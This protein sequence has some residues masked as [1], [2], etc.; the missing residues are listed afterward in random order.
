MKGDAAQPGCRGCELAIRRHT[1]AT[2]E[3]A[4][5]VVSAAREQQFG[6]LLRLVPLRRES[7]SSFV[8]AVCRSSQASGTNSIAGGG[9]LILMEAN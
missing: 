7:F 2:C 9:V 4:S 3:R 1:A 8:L 5:P 6:L